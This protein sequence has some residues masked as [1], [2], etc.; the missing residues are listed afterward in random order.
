MERE[1]GGIYVERR[2]GPVVWHLLRAESLA[3]WL[4]WLALGLYAFTRLV[5]LPA[6]PIYFFTDEAIQT[7]SAVDLITHHFYSPTGELLPTY[8]QNGSQYNLGV[9]VYLQVIPTLLFGKSIWVTRGTA[10][11][12]TL[13][14][15]VSVG[16]VLQRIFKNPYPWLAVMVL[17][18]TPAWFLH[19]R[20]AFETAL[21]AS[22]FALF[23]YFY[24]RYRADDPRWLFGALIAAALAF[25]SYSGMRP[26]L[27]VMG[28]LLLVSDGAYHWHHRRIMLAGI[29]LAVL[30]MLPLLRFL[31]AH[32]DASAWQ[33]RLLG[34]YWLTSAPLPQKLVDFALQYL[35]GL[36]P[37]YW[38]FPNTVDLSRHVMPGYGHLL[39]WSLPFGLLGLG[40]SLR[41][42]REPAYRALL[43]AVLAA[44]A[45]AALVQVGITRILVMVIPM[46]V[47][48][49]LGA[50]AALEW[51][52]AR[53]S[54]SRA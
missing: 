13:L 48:T 12:V 24:L 5:A 50:S 10:A 11:L 34:S 33:M 31:I 32:P 26:V 46:A 38:Y 4:T 20:T 39:R 54:L 23:L 49:A 3:G 8:F 28:L 37:V 7:V 9:S 44:P 25:Y 21:A 27:A 2:T 15:A 47:L 14:A 35:R 36:D 52:L 45:G 29:G 22:F 40:M 30:L 17:S 18:V 6:F 43:A 42:F 16:L 53:V 51:L 1:K 19:T 41:H